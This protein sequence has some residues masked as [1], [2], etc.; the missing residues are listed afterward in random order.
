MLQAFFMGHKI[1]NL[2]L[3]ASQPP[4][5]IRAVV[6]EG[7]LGEGHFPEGMSWRGRGLP[8]L[9]LLVLAAR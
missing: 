7:G 3:E 1:A 2:T 8:E 6:T 4:D 9:L 5:E